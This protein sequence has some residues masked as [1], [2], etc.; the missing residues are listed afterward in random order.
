MG[1]RASYGTS[2]RAPLGAQLV[3]GS[4]TT[5]LF[6]PIATAFKPYDNFGNPDLTP[7]TAENLNAGL[8]FNFGGFSASVDYYN[9]KLKD[10]VSSEP[11]PDIVRTFFGTNLAPV[12]NC[13]NAAF[14]GLQ[15]RF[16]FN[17]G[18]CAPQNLLRTRTIAVNGP[19]EETSGVDVSMKYTFN[20]VLRGDL[21]LGTDLTYLL[22]YVRDDF[23]VEGIV[24]QGAGGQDFAGT[25][26]QFNPLPELKGQVY[27]DWGS[28][29]QNLRLTTRY[30][31]SVTDLR[32]FV[33]NPVTG[34]AFEQGSFLTY[35]LVYRLSLPSQ[36]T[37]TASV[38]NLADRDPPFSRVEYSYDPFTANPFGRIIKIA[39]NKRF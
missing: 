8:F 19:D 16:T 28:D 4:L 34:E 22:E 32:A 1:V 13:G 6:T 20:N 37:V 5:L 7:E 21:T 35:D 24:I 9:I 38:L 12:N 29:R 3:S 25:R 18:V 10:P 17:T 27:A 14:A 39:A 15:S 26:G 2:F 33:A 23:L 11:G 30:V 31:D 36:T